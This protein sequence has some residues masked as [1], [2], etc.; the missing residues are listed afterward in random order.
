MTKKPEPKYLI[1]QTAPTEF[2]V[3]KWRKMESGWGIEARYKIAGGACECEG[4]K[5]RKDCKHLLMAAELPAPSSPV[6]LGEARELVALLFREFRRPRLIEEP[7]EKGELGLVRKITIRARGE[8]AQ[9][10]EGR[11]GTVGVRVIL[12]PK[13]VRP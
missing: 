4:F 11:F 5:H 2:G 12:E 1:L 7:Y 9:V 6:P 8:R 13:E 3:V 10:M